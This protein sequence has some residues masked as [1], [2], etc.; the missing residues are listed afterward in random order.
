MNNRSRI[1]ITGA[2]GFVGKHVMQAVSDLGDLISYS[3][4]KSDSLSHI[5]GEITEIDRI[6]PSADIVIHIAGNKRDET[7]MHRVNVEGTRAVLRYV[8][9]SGARL[10]HIG[11]GGVYG[12]YHHPET[13]ITEDS[14]CY[15]DNV[16]EKTK[17]EADRL[18]CEWGKSHPGHYMIL[19]PTNVIG[20]GDSSGKLLHLM[21]T[22]LG[23][24]FR[25]VDKKAMVNYVYV[26]KIGDV[27]R[28]I[29]EKHH[30]DNEIYTI[31]DPVPIESLIRMLCETLHIREIPPRL[32][33]LIQPFLFLMAKSSVLLPEKWRILTPG[34]YYELTSP[35]YYSSE[36]ADRTFPV[37]KSH[38]IHHGIRNLVAYYR[39]QHWL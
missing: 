36:K 34:K 19:R 38:D 2:S 3:R 17:L 37:N 10:I 39:D 1:L 23:G 22:L 11:S 18:I 6:S 30:F 5:T 21:K 7:S 9:K 29:I 24:K 13:R 15:P 8:E 31:N 27:V 35:K 28:Q 12:M 32:P 25:F 4:Q 26:K 14:A 16:Y 20:E 33:R